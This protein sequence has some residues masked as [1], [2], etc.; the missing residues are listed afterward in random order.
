VRVKQEVTSADVFAVINACETHGHTPAFL[1]VTQQAYR[2]LALSIFP[3]RWNHAPHML[4]DDCAD[5]DCV[6]LRRALRVKPG[7]EPGTR[8]GVPVRI[9]AD[10][11]PPIVA[12]HGGG[13]AQ[14]G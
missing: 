2:S 9:V 14:H 1:E 8:A 10:P 13:G 6:A 3:G 12:V 4:T 5:A 7:D 11:P